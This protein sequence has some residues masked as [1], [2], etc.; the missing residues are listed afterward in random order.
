MA[1][2]K[3]TGKLAYSFAT[4]EDSTTTFLR[5]PS[6]VPTKTT[7]YPLVLVAATEVNFVLNMATGT[8]VMGF[9][10]PKGEFTSSPQKSSPIVCSF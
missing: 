3:S 4:D 2:P 5:Y 10:P 8:E 9:S 1:E 7:V 6:V